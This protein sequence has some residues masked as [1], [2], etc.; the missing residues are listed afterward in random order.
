MGPLD[1]AAAWSSAAGEC[2][3]LSVPVPWKWDTAYVWISQGPI[4]RRER[5]LAVV[6]FE[7]TRRRLGV[8]SCLGARGLALN[9]VGGTDRHRNY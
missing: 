1:D 2:P 6:L 9:K 5:L 7:R 3:A 4:G 8:K